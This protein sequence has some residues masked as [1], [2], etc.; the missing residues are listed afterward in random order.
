MLPYWVLIGVFIAGSLFDRGQ[1]ASGPRWML[2]LG[3][4]L[5]AIMVGLRFE[6]GADW[7]TYQ[8]YLNFARFLDF[9]D[10]IDLPDPGY[11]FVNIVAARTIDQLWAV[12][13]VC[14][15]IFGWGLF[16]FAKSQP[17]PWLTMVVAIPYLVTVVAMGY[18]RQ[19]VA[20]GILMAG[21][22]AVERGAS[23]ARFTIYVA[24]A[25][26]FHRTAVIMLPLLIF[27]GRRTTLLSIIAAIVGSYALYDLFVA[28]SVDSFVR[29]YVEA[30][31]SS[32]GA[33][34]RVAMNLVPAILFLLFRRRMGFVAGAD[35]LWLFM[36]LVA[37]VTVPLLFLIA[38]STAVDRL[39]LYIIPLQ[40]VVLPR[41]A[42]LFGN[43]QIGRIAVI[44]Y[45]VVTLAIW[46]LF[47]SHAQFWLPYRFYPLFG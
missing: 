21:L 43:E 23:I 46:L 29:N 9:G 11:I 6:V 25:T 35:R 20:I 1:R 27:A 39:A 13:L 3:A 47:A 44:A 36:S 24:F 14:G 33:G 4:L 42:R 45:A 7:F 10:L 28:E 8:A 2:G 40:L 12:N 26:L 17:D 38:S 19:A 41:S 31:Y 32:Q 5:I 16:R 15:I 34:I 18:S 37:I 22:A 30:R